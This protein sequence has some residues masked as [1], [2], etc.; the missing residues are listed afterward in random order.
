MGFV[1][2]R[3]FAEG[4]GVTWPRDVA[5]VVDGRPVTWREVHTERTAH[6]QR[7]IDWK[8]RSDCRPPVFAYVWVFENAS[9]IYMG[10]YCYLVYLENGRVQHVSINFRG[11]RDRLAASL[12]RA[13]P[14]GLLSLGDGDSGFERWMEAF[15][16]RYPR[17]KPRYDRRRAGV[18]FVRFDREAETVTRVR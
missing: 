8:R 9:W 3:S 1:M 11:Y 10:W 17:R 4:L 13:F 16:A 18:A 14:L 7:A 5:A 15:A 6:Q 12:M 2:M